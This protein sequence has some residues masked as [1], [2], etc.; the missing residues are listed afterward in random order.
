MVDSTDAATD[1][2][3]RASEHFGPR[4][5]VDETADA[6]ARVLAFYGRRAIK[7]RV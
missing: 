4:L 7:R 1:E 5:D 3:M 6:Q 2:A